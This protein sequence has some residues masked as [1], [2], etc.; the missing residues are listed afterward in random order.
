MTDDLYAVNLDLQVSL[1]RL[2]EDRDRARRALE[3][4]L[5]GAQTHTHELFVTRLE[6]DLCLAI[7]DARALGL[8][9]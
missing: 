3:M 7:G 6:C 1:D 4:I 9:T 2:R 8:L 5:R